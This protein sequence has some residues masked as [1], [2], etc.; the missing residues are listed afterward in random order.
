MQNELVGEIAFPFPADIAM[1]VFPSQKTNGVLMRFNIDSKPFFDFLFKATSLVY[2][3]V[4]VGVE[5]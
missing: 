4:W 1:N 2:Y 5:F 3:V